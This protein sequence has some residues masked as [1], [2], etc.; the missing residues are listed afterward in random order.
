MREE[1]VNLGWF[2]AFEEDIDWDEDAVFLADK[3][4]GVHVVHAKAGGDVFE[5]E[6]VV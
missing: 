6:G 5:Y 2:E 3:V 1:I 4:S